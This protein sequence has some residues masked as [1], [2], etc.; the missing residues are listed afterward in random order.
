MNPMAAFRAAM[1]RAERKAITPQHDNLLRAQVVHSLLAAMQHE[2][3]VTKI[4]TRVAA[5]I[6]ATAALPIAQ[7]EVAAMAAA[8]PLQEVAAATVV[9]AAHRLEAAERVAAHQVAAVRLADLLQDRL[10]EV[11]AAVEA[12]GAKS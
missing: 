7:A 2:A 5:A 4:V 3:A 8:L 11:A 1:R 12:E 10:R 9:A 6:A